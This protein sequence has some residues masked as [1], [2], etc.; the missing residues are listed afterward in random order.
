M[1]SF[2]PQGLSHTAGGRYSRQLPAV[3]CLKPQVQL[4]LDDAGL[5]HHGL[6]AL[7]AQDNVY[8]PDAQGDSSPLVPGSERGGFGRGQ[9][10]TLSKKGNGPP[11]LFPAKGHPLKQVHGGASP[12]RRRCTGFGDS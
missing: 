9:Q 6:Y 2:S 3:L 10:V 1:H 5:L 7:S 4:R 8:R 12:Q 11:L